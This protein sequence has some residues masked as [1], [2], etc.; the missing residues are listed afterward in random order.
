MWRVETFNVRAYRAEKHLD[1]FVLKLLKDALCVD[2]QTYS[3]IY[4]IG[5]DAGLGGAWSCSARDMN[6]LRWRPGSAVAT[7]AHNSSPQQPAPQHHLQL[8]AA[9]SEEAGGSKDRAVV[10][11]MYFLAS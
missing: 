5:V 7:A 2:Y 10:D 6:E 1:E 8:G 9:G 11:K 4:D 3:R